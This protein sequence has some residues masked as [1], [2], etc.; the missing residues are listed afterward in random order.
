MLHLARPTANVLMTNDRSLTNRPAARLRAG[1]SPRSAPRLACNQSGQQIPDPIIGG[2]WMAPAEVLAHQ[3]NAHFV[4][5]KR[6]T[7]LLRRFRAAHP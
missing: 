7:Q 2:I 4:Q 1:A 6:C 5:F 3:L